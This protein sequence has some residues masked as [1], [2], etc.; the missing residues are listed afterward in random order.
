[1]QIEEEMLAETRERADI[2]STF[3]LGSDAPV[4]LRKYGSSFRLAM[5]DTLIAQ[6]AQSDHLLFL[7][8]GRLRTTVI[9]RNNVHRV[10]S[11]FLPG[12]IVGEIAFYAGI[13]RTATITAET[14]ATVVRM[15]AASLALM[16]AEDPAAAARFHRT[17]ATI[18]ARRLMTT[19]RLLNDAER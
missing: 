14:D 5:G 10:V 19:T 1:M 18:L 6:G 8:D 4:L 3:D 7:V 11:R 9:D 15:D 12:A 2:E 16:E 17:L 13:D